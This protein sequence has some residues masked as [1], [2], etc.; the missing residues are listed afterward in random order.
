MS[1]KKPALSHQKHLPKKQLSSFILS[2]VATKPTPRC[3]E[4]V[5]HHVQHTTG[6]LRK[7][8]KIPPQKKWVPGS[9]KWPYWGLW[10]TSSGGCKWP[11]IRVI[12]K[13]V[14]WKRLIHEFVL[15]KQTMVYR[16]K[17]VWFQRCWRLPLC[18]VHATSPNDEPNSPKIMQPNSSFTKHSKDGYTWNQQIQSN[19]FTIISWWVIKVSS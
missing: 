19:R 12:K 15:S 17:P 7:S 6:D 4:W 2:V 13:T 9:S 11:S 5:R 16:Y 3:R 8:G 18:C 14:T 10:V 1:F